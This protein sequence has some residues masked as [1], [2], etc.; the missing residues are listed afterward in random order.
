[1]LR[2]KQ[3]RKNKNTYLSCY[4]SSLVLFKDRRS[5]G[6]SSLRSD[7]QSSPRK[8][9]QVSSS[10]GFLRDSLRA[11]LAQVAPRWSRVL[12]RKTK[13]IL[14]IQYHLFFL[15]HYNIAITILYFVRSGWIG[16]GIG[17]WSNLGIDGFY[18]SSLESS[19]HNSG[20]MTSSAFT[21][22]FGL[23]ESHPDDGPHL[24]RN[25]FPLRWLGSGGGN[26]SN[27]CLDQLIDQCLW[28]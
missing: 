6:P 22:Y 15:K 2:R 4:G 11:S 12:P 27:G 8:N 26:H 20:T 14:P 9:S 10:L 25:G 7:S 16:I 23:D 19:K 18:W 28:R 1:M 17:N 5:R 13:Q 3:L 24:L 21:P